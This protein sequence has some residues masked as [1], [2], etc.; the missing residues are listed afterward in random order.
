M[1]PIADFVAELNTKYPKEGDYSSM[2]IYTTGQKYYRI[3]TSRDG[4][5]PECA[6]GFVD[7]ETGD[8]FKSASWNAPA[9]IKRGN[10]NDVSGLNACGRYG[11]QHLR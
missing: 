6:Y 11:I 8:L 9:K 7:I 2:Y 4:I 1:K 5:T 3:C 10:I